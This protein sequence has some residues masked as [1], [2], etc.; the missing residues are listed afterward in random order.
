MT[1]QNQHK[2]IDEV[3]EKHGLKPYIPG[4]CGDGWADLIDRL[5]TDLVAL[6]WNR[7]LDQCK[8]KYACYDSE[9]EVLTENGWKFFKDVTVED[10]IATLGAN[11]ALEY[12]HPTDVI[13][14]S[15]CGR[16]YKLTTRGVDLLVTPN[17]RLYVAKGATWNGRYKPPIKK[18]HP[19][20][21]HLPDEMF[22]LNK[23]FQKGTKWNGEDLPSFVLPSVEWSHTTQKGAMGRP[24]SRLYRKPE[25][26]LPMDAWLHFLG[27]YIAEGC[28]SPSKPEVSVAANNTDGGIEASVVERAIIAAEFQPRLA[29]ADNPAVV[30]KIYDTQLAR[31]LRSECGMRAHNKKVPAFVKSLSPRQITIFLQALFAGDG[32]KTKTAHILCTTSRRLADDVQELLLKAGYSS[33]SFK[34]APY[35]SKLPVGNRHIIARHDVYNVNWLKKSYYHNTASNKDRRA[36]VERWEPYQGEVHCVTV[37]NGIIHVRRNGIPVWCGNSLRF[38]IGSGTEEMFDRIDQAEMES[39]R[40]CEVCGEPGSLDESEWWIMTLCDKHKEMRAKGEDIWWTS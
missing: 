14:A 29:C 6:G 33:Y 25:R 4:G 34:R 32:H 35:N 27:W 26:V 23:R 18:A 37:P 17:H 11:D 39:A 2:T 40:T 8:S 31:W 5:I 10:R 21:F 36:A 7:Q 3:L 19:F 9:T 28:T 16:M 13:A 12:Q 24:Y 30:F 20:G 1:M 38:Y 22:G 15:Y